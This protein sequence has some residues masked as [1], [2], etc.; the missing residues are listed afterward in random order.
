VIFDDLARPSIRPDFAADGQR[1]YFGIDDRQSDIWV[2]EIA[3]K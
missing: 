3:R 1:F 2:A